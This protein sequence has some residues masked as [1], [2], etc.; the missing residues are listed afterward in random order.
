VR[1][2][3]WA[4]D[5]GYSVTLVSGKR[6]NPMKSTAASIPCYYFDKELELEEAERKRLIGLKWIC[7]QHRALS[8]ISSAS[9]ARGNGSNG[10]GLLSPYETGTNRGEL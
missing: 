4:K 2:I 5:I 3:F 1:L 8:Y 7:A 10:D 6:I 9:P